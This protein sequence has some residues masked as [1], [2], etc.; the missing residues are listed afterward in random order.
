MRAHLSGDLR[1]GEHVRPLKFIV[2]DD[3]RLV[4]PVMVAMIECFDT[5]LAL[6][7]DNPESLHVQ[8]ALEPFDEHGPHGR[9]ADRW[10]AYHG[11][12][13]DVRWAFLDIDA[14]RLDGLFIDGL[15]LRQPNALAADEP[16]LCKAFN[17]RRDDVRRVC[18]RR[19]GKRIEEPVV[20]GVDPL[21]FDV[22]GTFD[23]FR[24][25]VDEPMTDATSVRRA[26]DAMAA[27]T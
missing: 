5:V 23:V 4:A 24:L 14:A 18:E 26:F 8:V 19:L 9:V 21:G 15:A 17:A 3:G 2:A 11:E 7:D 22:R 12:P 10:R 16:A 6:P 13:P 1:F 20:V 27:A 25:E